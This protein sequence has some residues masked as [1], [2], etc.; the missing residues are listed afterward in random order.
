MVLLWL[1]FI[2]VRTLN[3]YLFMELKVGDVVELKSGGP[4]MTVEKTPV[5]INGFE[6]KDRAQCCWFDKGDLKR[7]VFPLASLEKDE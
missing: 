6:Y 2:V 1:E 4:S 5:F 7:E 3:E